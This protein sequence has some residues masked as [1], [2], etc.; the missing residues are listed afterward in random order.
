LRPLAA[1][2]C[3]IKRLYLAPEARGL[4]LGR[5]LVAA[6]L[7]GARRIGYREARLD[8]L[9]TMAAAMALYRRAGFVEIA[10]YYPTPVAGTRFFAC[11]L[12]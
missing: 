3:E 9:P 4:G 7:A 1:D 5:E 2:V 11:P 8:T 6:V 10:A 12:G